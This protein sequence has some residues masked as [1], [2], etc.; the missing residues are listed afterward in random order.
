[1]KRG[2]KSVQG[3]AEK[4]EN[5]GEKLRKLSKRG[6][7]TTP[8]V[9]YWRLKQLEFQLQKQAAPPHA[10]GAQVQD[11]TFKNTAF[12]LPCVSSRKLGA[13]F[14]ELQHY[15]LPLSK[16]HQGVSVPPPRLRR[17]HHQPYKDKGSLEPPDP[18]PC[19]PDQPGSA[20]SVRRQVAA[21]LMQHHRSIE[22]THRA[23]QPVSPASYGSSMEITPYNP[24]VTPTSSIDLKGRFGETSQSLKT[25]TEL[26]KVLN[27][28]WTLEEQHVSNMSLVRALKKELDNARS[29]IK[30]LVREQQTERL[31]MDDLM[32]QIK[33]DTIIRKNKE[34]DR[35]N[36]AILSLREEL[37][38]ER[39]LRKRSESLHRKLARELFEVKTTLASTSKELEKEK[40]SSKLLED[41]CDEFAW[42]IRDYEQELHGVRQKYDKDWTERADQDRLILHVSESWLDERMQMKLEPDSALGEKK[43]IVEKLSSEIEAFL[44]AR[45]GNKTNGNLGQRDPNIRR[46]SLESIPLNAA[47]SAPRDEDDEDDSAG[48]DSN[49][50][51]LA[52]PSESKL[53][54]LENEYEENHYDETLKEK[55]AKT[56]I[57]SSERTKGLSP[58]SLQVKFEEQMARALSDQ[59]EDTEPT[60]IRQG[61][62]VEISISQ[63]SEKREAAEEN[64]SRRKNKYEGETELNSNYMIDNLI[65]NHYLLSESG[66]LQPDN[67]TGQASIWRSHASPVRR[68]TATLPSHDLGISESSLKL[69]PDSKEH[70]LKAKLLEARTRAQR[71]RSRLKASIIPSRVV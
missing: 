54:S 62:P 35:I 63:K 21:S 25:S 6:G 44:R 64:S 52:K 30:E 34:Q 37:E 36:A 50:F 45:S 60:K 23:I 56:K 59:V 32:K 13:T 49:C 33:E 31:E 10:G 17:L 70:T 29:R 3:P 16:M 38:N 22:R 68:W 46:N 26:L 71:S 4:E 5:L 48:S 8:V 51:E 47:V 65:R 2:E 9:P 67:D 27:R 18:S 15:K 53:K 40:K 66:K 43:L 69:P 28:I 57:G 7:H 20:G 39:K 58:S 12:T 24:A 19:S 42:G 11:S 41:L 1:M 61:N 14:W 55:P